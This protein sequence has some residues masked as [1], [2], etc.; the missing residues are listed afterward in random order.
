MLD[1]GSSL[2]WDISLN[3][4]VDRYLGKAKV[5]TLRHGQKSQLPGALKKACDGS[6]W[7]VLF[8]E[9]NA[10]LERS[11]V[12]F[13]FLPYTNG[14]GDSQLFLNW[15]EALQE[16]FWDARALTTSRKTCVREATPVFTPEVW[17]M[18][19]TGTSL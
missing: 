5:V 11:R 6:D 12:S 19:E 13:S 4:Y 9:F 1:D 2:R 3:V 14:Q 8:P 17:K 15:Q 18:L 16:Q 7:E 10:W